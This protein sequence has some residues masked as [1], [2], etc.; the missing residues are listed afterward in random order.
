MISP[1]D[2][3]Q[4]GMSFRALCLLEAN[5]QVPQRDLAEVLG[6][7]L[8]SANYCLRALID[9]GMVKVRNFKASKHKL[10]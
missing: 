2:I 8:G 4:E 1:R 3:A 7:S 6:Q 10:S 5:P 9:A